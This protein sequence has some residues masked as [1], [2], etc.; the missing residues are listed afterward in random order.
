[1]PVFWPTLYI[2]TK[3]LLLLIT[4][5]FSDNVLKLAVNILGY[6]TDR[7]KVDKQ[8]RV[9]YFFSFGESK[10]TIIHKNYKLKPTTVQKH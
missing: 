1:V 3:I 9:N 5:H 4:P 6:L 10:S 8:N 2:I 7:K